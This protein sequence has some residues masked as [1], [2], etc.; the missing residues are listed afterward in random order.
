M[1]ERIMIVIDG[2]TVT[3]SCIRQG[4]ELARVHHANVV[5]LYLLPAASFSGLESL[6][7]A[8]AAD[9]KLRRG[10]KAYGEKILSQACEA[11]EAM[12]IHCFG[13]MGLGEDNAQC[14][15][16]AANAQHCDAIVVGIEGRNAVFRLLTGNIVPGLISLATLPVI[17]CR[18]TET[19]RDYGQASSGLART[20][21]KREE[22]T[23]RR[24][25]AADTRSH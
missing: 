12:D 19:V 20:K 18:E 5:F 23:A 22:L 21:L 10:S 15:V 6:S 7:V 17:V 11:S 2:R 25:Q 8:P 3:Q 4:L 16:E 1:Y 14:V 9:E 24:T 13:L